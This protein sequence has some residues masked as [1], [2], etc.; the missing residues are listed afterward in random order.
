MSRCA[1]STLLI[2]RRSPDLVQDYMHIFI[3]GKELKST[4]YS[5]HPLAMSSA[6]DVTNRQIHIVLRIVGLR[7]NRFL[8]LLRRLQWAPRMTKHLRQP[9]AVTCMTWVESDGALHIRNPSFLVVRGPFLCFRS[10]EKSENDR[11]I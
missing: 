3:L 7:R 1:R 11:L 4:I 10:G 2:Q 8:Q 5:F 9:E 6:R